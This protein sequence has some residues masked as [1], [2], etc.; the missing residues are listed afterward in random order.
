MSQIPHGCLSERED[1]LV[2]RVLPV[3]QVVLLYPDVPPTMINQEG[4]V[5]SPGHVSDVPEDGYSVTMGAIPPELTAD[6][7]ISQNLAYCPDFNF[8]AICSA[9]T[10]AFTEQCTA[11]LVQERV[12]RPIYVTCCK[13][14]F[15]RDFL[16]MDLAQIHSFLRRAFGY[17]VCPRIVG[18]ALAY[19]C[20]N[21][22][23]YIKEYESCRVAARNSA[24]L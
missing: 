4:S 3:C 10:M 11:R 20:H 21:W 18:F 1:S 2:V 6:A 22:E 19:T 14:K 7:V 9:N 23:K 13:L 12:T 17:D 24:S 16:D 5:S 8:S 15:F